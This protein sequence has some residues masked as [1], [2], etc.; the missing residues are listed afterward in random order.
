MDDLPKE[1]VDSIDW[2]RCAI[3]GS[4]ALKKFT[5]AKWDHN[6]V[7]VYIPV[8]KYEEHVSKIISKTNA[9]EIPHKIYH[10]YS[11]V[12]NVR[13]YRIPQ[14]DKNIQLIAVNTETQP[15]KDIEPYYDIDTPTCVSLSQDTNTDRLIFIVPE[16]CIEKINGS[17]KINRKYVS[18][19][20]VEKYEKRGFTYTK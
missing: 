10:K 17:K 13:T 18:E 4:Y 8:D 5:N 7:D 16:G 1:F 9:K 12:H 2:S 6:D 19:E 11:N 20:V 3:G 14:Y 15:V